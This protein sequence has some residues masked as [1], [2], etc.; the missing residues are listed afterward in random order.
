MLSRMAGTPAIP[1]FAQVRV[2]SVSAETREIND[3][4]GYVI[5]VSNRP[6]DDGRFGYGVFVYDLSKVW[7]CTES[8]LDPTGELDKEA[9]RDQKRERVRHR[10]L[11][12]SWSS[13][14]L[15]ALGQA[16]VFTPLTEHRL[17]NWLA[18]GFALVPLYVVFTIHYLAVPIFSFTVH[19]RIWFLSLFWFAGFAVLSE[20]LR[21]V[22]LLP[23][24]RFASDIVPRVMMHLGWLSFIPLIWS[25]R[26]YA[27]NR[28][29]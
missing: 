8:E 25:Y 22:G 4:L 13:L 2:R 17:P 6:Q 3:R 27:P 26:A 18:V 15:A 11:I 1:L 14:L 10:M 28:T 16:L 29:G 23:P 24:G 19:H 21:A 5:G 7:R 20:L 12:L 9:M